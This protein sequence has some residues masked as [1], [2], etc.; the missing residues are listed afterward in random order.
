MRLGIKGK[1]VFGVTVIVTMVVV[2]LSLVHLAQL[3]QVTLDE[4]RARADLLAKA[5]FHRA[6]D[7]VR[8]DTVDP[9]LVLRADPGL[10]SIL[11]SSLYSKNVT[12][13]AIVDATGVAIAHA[14]SAQEGRVLPVA[15]DLEA[16][17]SHSSFYQLRAIYQGQGRNFD[18]NQRLLVGD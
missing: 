18:L 6:H 7:I 8:E 12:F 1:Q 10:R 16:L 2:L 15:A 3:A 9:Y 14:D 4:S 17:L 5:I 13:A 11:E